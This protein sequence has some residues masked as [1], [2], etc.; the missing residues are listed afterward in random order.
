MFASALDPGMETPTQKPS[1]ILSHDVLAARL[2]AHLHKTLSPSS[3]PRRRTSLV[4]RVVLVARALSL[5]PAPAS[6]VRSDLPASPLLSG[7]QPWRAPPLL[8]LRDH[9]QILRFR[10]R[11]RKPDRPR[12]LQLPDLLKPHPQLHLAKPSS[13]G[14][15]SSLRL[16]QLH[17]AQVGER[18][19]QPPS[20]Q[21]LSQTAQA[22]NLA[23]RRQ[24]SS[25]MVISSSKAIAAFVHF[26]HHL[27][28]QVLVATP[29]YFYV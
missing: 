11:S 8:W 20:L 4:E 22:K 10:H 24:A 17:H 23:S 16:G 21:A 15:K 19:R 27:D 1:K 5:A 3:S 26:H 7:V 29:L 18:H 28:A 25:E 9:Q 14:P 13:Q 12:A 2:Q 6:V